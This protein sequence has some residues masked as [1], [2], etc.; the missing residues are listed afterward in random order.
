MAAKPSPS[1][2]RTERT[3]RSA[4][5]SFARRDATI[6]DSDALSILTDSNP[7]GHPA[8]LIF[9]SV[10]CYHENGAMEKH[11]S[12]GRDDGGP[13]G[14]EV[15]PGS[16]EAPES[17]EEET[18][19][20]VLSRSRVG[21]VLALGIVPF[22]LPLDYVRFPDSFGSVLVVR[23]VGL[24]CLLAVLAASTLVSSRRA[25]GIAFLTVAFISFLVV[26]LIPFTSGPTDPV[27]LAQAMAVIVVILGVGI[28]LPVDPRRVL[29]LGLVPFSMQVGLSFGYPIVEHLPVLL[30]GAT[31]LVVSTVG[32]RSVYENRL[33]AHRGRIAQADLL[34][35][36][37]DFAAALTHDLKNPLGLIIQYGEIVREKSGANLD[38]EGALALDRIEA[39]A[40]RAMML[41]TNLL[42]MSRVEAGHL[43]LRSRTVD[44]PAFLDRMAG[45]Q[46]SSL[47]LKGLRFD[48]EVDPAV[49]S[50]EAD[51]ALLERVFVNLLDNAV[52]VA[53]PGG[54]V[55]LTA[56]RPSQGTVEIAVEDSG[57]GVSPELRRTIFQRFSRSAERA[58]S[59][60]LGLFVVKALT[61]AH[62]GTVSV[63]DRPAGQGACF[64]LTLPIGP[65]SAS[66]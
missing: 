24:G 28:L 52:R 14:P 6:L 59:T 12:P 20:L 31:A 29:L 32:A 48:L 26:G 64:R 4:P 3:A 10:S 61:E 51:E 18:R 19:K 16:L 15:T 21:C 2:H 41:S 49:R 65:L 27:Y 9:A 55:R 62:G 46:R 50:I 53:P 13:P 45:Y 44:L 40:R 66:A 8:S 57:P 23:F 39:S 36:R 43:R 47:I 5:G 37:T 38:T 34:R 42:E 33:Q 63:D 17:F 35:A 30:S 22:F 60:G 11:F 56:T 54:F 58:D 7:T 25:F 1:G